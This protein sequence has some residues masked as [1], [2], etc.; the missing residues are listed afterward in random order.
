MISRYDVIRYFV[1]LLT[2]GAIAF[3]SSVAAQEAKTKFKIANS[4]LSV[5]SPWN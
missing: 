4:A 5:T 2:V 1:L 3:S